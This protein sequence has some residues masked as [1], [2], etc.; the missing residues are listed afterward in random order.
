MKITLFTAAFCL[1]ACRAEVASVQPGD[2]GRSEGGLVDAAVRDAAQQAP[3]LAPLEHIDPSGTGGAVGLLHFGTFGDIRPPLPDDVSQYP[4]AVATAIFTGMAKT[5]PQF[6]V[7]TGDYMFAE[8]SSSMVQQQL[9]K[10]AEAEQP[11]TVPIF[12]A[13]GNHECNSLSDLNCPDLNESSNI[14]TYLSS[15]VP[16]TNGVPWFA[17]TIHTSTGD[18]KFIFIAANAWNAT[19]A[20]WLQQAVAVPTKYTFIVR[21][22]PSP[23]AGSSS[24]NGGV[25]ASDAII[26]GRPVT[27]WLFGHVHEYRHLTVNSVI[28][29]NAGAPLTHGEYGWLDVTQRPDGTVGVMAYSMSTGLPT[30]AWAVTADGAGA[31]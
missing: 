27:L 20:A 13:M 25:T 3:D 4:T 28:A 21:H 26:A 2:G 11:I 8:F 9:A 16:W 18:A 14:K 30:D 12:H 24:P 1:V 22:T 29:G 5:K 31:P 7:G 19:Q 17:F 15:L 6:V 23:D 10:L